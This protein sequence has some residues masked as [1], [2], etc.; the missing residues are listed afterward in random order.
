[1]QVQV[2][3]RHEGFV[4]DLAFELLRHTVHELAHRVRYRSTNILALDA[5]RG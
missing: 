5:V 2:Y 3:H 4:A 1:M